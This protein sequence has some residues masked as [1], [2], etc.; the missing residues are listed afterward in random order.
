MAAVIN[1]CFGSTAAELS[2]CDKEQK[3]ATK[4]KRFSLCFFYKI[5]ANRWS[6]IKILH[7][8]EMDLF[9]DI[10]QVPATL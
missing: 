8:Q 4:L 3:M 5:F 10:S 7:E 6:R 1:G 2:S 9:I